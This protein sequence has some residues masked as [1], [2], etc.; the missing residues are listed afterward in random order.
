[1]GSV[2]FWGMAMGSCE[3]PVQRRPG[4][5]TAEEATS[6]RPIFFGEAQNYPSSSYTPLSGCFVCCF[7][8]QINYSAPSSERK[9]QW[10]DAILQTYLN[11][12]E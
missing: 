11:L 1:V 2:E 4:P 5:R 9:R 3:Q 10:L 6:R 12:S 7:S 8:T